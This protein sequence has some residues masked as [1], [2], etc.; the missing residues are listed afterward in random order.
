MNCDK[1][2]DRLSEGYRGF[3]VI[4]MYFK[5]TL[6]RLSTKTLRTLIMAVLPM[7]SMISLMVLTEKTASLLKFMNSQLL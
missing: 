3:N 4:F 5:S 7:I 2:N 6:K 1:F